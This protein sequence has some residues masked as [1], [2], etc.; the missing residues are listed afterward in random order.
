MMLNLRGVRTAQDWALATGI[1][2]SSHPSGREE[3]PTADETIESVL[4][5]RWRTSV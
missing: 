2:G 5:I 4:D 3:N 1:A